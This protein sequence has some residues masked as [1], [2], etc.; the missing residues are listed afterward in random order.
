MA[1]QDQPT[2]NW[3]DAHANKGYVHFWDGHYQGLATS[4]NFQTLQCRVEQRV[5]P[6]DP[7]LEVHPSPYL[8]TEF[9]GAEGPASPDHAATA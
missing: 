2:N 9:T 4:Q 3:V 6:Q 5:N 1:G 8:G 7:L